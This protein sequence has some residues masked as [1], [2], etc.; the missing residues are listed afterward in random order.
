MALMFR[1]LLAT[2]Y[3]HI[4]PWS[5]ISE[6]WGSSD[7][8]ADDEQASIGGW[9]TNKTS[10]KKSQVWW[11]SSTVSKQTLPWIFDKQ[12]PQRRISTL[13]MLGTLTLFQHLLLFTKGSGATGPTENLNLYI[14]LMTDN[15]GNAL[16]ILNNN[17]KKWPTS[18]VLME[19]VTQ[20][21]IHEAAIGPMHIK[22]SRNTWADALAGMDHT[23]FDQERRLPA[24]LPAHWH[25]L[26]PTTGLLCHHSDDTVLTGQT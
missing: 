10:P 6:W 9:I 26:G 1:D 12:T 17:S 23:G 3:K 8:S 24:L 4:S 15:Q 21:H 13:E 16:S 2:P 19:L 25:I 22:R 14:P 7:A 20:A 11:F 18:A 5:P